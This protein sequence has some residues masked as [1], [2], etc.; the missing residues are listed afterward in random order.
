MIWLAVRM[1]MGDRAKYFGLVFSI[2]FASMLMAQQASIFWGL[3]KRTTSQIEDVREPDVWVMNRETMYVDEV[4]P[5]RD[6][7]LLRVR[8]VSGVEWAVPLHRSS[9]RLKGDGGHFRQIVLVGVDDASL[10]GAPRKMI[11]GD[12]RALR[13]AEAVII[14]TAAYAHFWPG[15]PPATGRV[16]EINDHRAIIVGVCETSTPFV[17]IP[18]AYVSMS[19]VARIVPAETGRVSYVLAKAGLEGSA[20][21]ARRIATR[22]GLRAMTDDEFA[23]ATIA[24]YMQHTG[25]PINFGI[26]VVLAFIV[27]AAIAGQTF[28]VFTLENMRQLGALKAMGVENRR[29][30][31]MTVVQALLVGIMGYGIGIGLC[32]LFFESTQHVADLRGFCLSAPIAAGV[33]AAVLGIMLVAALISVRRVFVL[34]PATVFRG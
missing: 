32:A 2:A 6:D 31:G 26:T 5:L 29:L 27:G 18:T 12:A 24:Y 21:I 34:E 17:T 28:F 15:E 10:V 33:A 19:E 25:I 7:D 3:M 23:Q 14:D 16:V 8:D 30:L 1:L 9:A 4:S 13:G 20:A 11:A 22:T